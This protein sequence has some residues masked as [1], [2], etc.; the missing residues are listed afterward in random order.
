MN[1]NFIKILSEKLLVWTGERWIISLSKTEGKKTIYDKNLEAKSANLIKEENS[2]LARKLLLTF[3]DA[4]LID[5]KEDE[6]D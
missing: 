4:K 1:K 5:V 3:P 2:E 6:N